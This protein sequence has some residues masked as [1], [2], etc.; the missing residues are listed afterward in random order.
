V[1][2][3]AVKQKAKAAAAVLRAVFEECKKTKSLEMCTKTGAIVSVTWDRDNEGT[4]DALSPGSAARRQYAIHYFFAE[5]FGAPKEEDWA[6]PNF[7]LR[8]SL[9]RVIMD[10][11]SLPATSKAAV[12]TAMEAVSDAREAKQECNPPAAIKAGA[13]PRS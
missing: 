10:M 12:I 7:H 5:V 8:L 4:R 13:A 11:L 3:T 1:A 9:P 2:C 6:A